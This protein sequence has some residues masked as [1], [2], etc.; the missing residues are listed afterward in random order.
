[1]S[2]QEEKAKAR[3]AAEAA[4][5]SSKS[6]TSSKDTSTGSK[7]FN[8]AKL[9][10]TTQAWNA[11]SSDAQSAVAIH[12]SQLVKAIDK[13][14]PLPE[15]LDAKTMANLWTQAQNDPTIQKEYADE[16]STASNFMSK[17]IATLSANYQTLTQQQKQAYINAQKTL[18][19]T[20]A[21]AGQAYSG[22]RQQASNQLGAAQSD[23][24]QSA[25]S[26]L[27]SQL[28]TLQSTYEQKFGSTDLSGMNIA[29]INAYGGDLTGGAYTGADYG[30]TAYTPVGGI[31]GTQTTDPNNGMIA[32]ELTKQQDLANTQIT[33]NQLQ[34]VQNSKNLAAAYAKLGLPA[35]S[36]S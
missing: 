12:A 11:L 30:S 9:G 33:A 4:K 23:T 18:D 8:Y 15:Q 29:G 1:M 6:K 19:T 17:N 5:K 21:Q 24:V 10:V 27:Q 32:A 25:Q 35:P 14:Q 20:S 36:N 31:T 3:A 7:A 28:N 16:L 13:N 22:V 34:N 26:D 2:T